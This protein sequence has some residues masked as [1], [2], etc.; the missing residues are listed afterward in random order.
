MLGTELH[1]LLDSSF[2][3]QR[4]PSPIGRILELPRHGD[5]ASAALRAMQAMSC[6]VLA[7]GVGGLAGPSLTTLALMLVHRWPAGGLTPDS[8][9]LLVDRLGARCGCHSDRAW[10]SEKIEKAKCQSRV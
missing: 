1:W 5:L 4:R 6:S 9:M 2:A 8:V 7:D 3:E 10:P